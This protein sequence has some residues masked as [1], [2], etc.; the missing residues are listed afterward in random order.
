ML[1]NIIKRNN[2]LVKYP[3]SR[4]ISVININGFVEYIIERS[5]YP[6]DKCQDILKDD[7]V[8]VIGYGP[9]GRGQSL[10]LKDNN[11]NVCLGLRKGSSWDTALGDG[12][13]EGKDLFEIEEACCRSSIIQ[14]LLSDVGQIQQ[15][16]NVKNYLDEGDTL[17]FSHG[18][19]ITFEDKTNIIP[20]E[21][22]D[23][24]FSCTKGCRINSKRPFP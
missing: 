7:I 4:Y 2:N 9:Q 5:D 11:I 10:N 23:V 19:G 17:Y 20:P 22:V 3:V 24:V 1:W 18:F 14:Y 6:I 16:D 8:S 13:I 12:W 21:D 15:W